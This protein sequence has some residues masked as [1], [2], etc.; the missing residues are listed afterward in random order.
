MLKAVDL[1]FFSPTGGT[2]KAGGA[3]ACGISENVNEHDLA[4]KTLNMPSSDAVIVAVP[5]FAGRIPAFAA[6]KL[7]KLNGIGKKAVTAVVYGVRAYD[8]A[9]IEL[10]DIMKPPIFL[11][12]RSNR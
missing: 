6:E 7:A 9:L 4:E 8:D 11:P 1:Y 2:K 3:L 5:V 10:N 12:I